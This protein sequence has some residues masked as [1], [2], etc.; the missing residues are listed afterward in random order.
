MKC[1]E[2]GNKLTRTTGNHRYT[3]CGLKNIILKNIP[4]FIC[5]QCGEEE[6]IIQN[7]EG[8]HNLIATIVASQV[9][10]LLPEEIRLLRTHLGFSGVDFARA[11]DVTPESVSRWET[12]KEKMS[13]SLERFLRT[14]ILY[15]FGPF[16]NYEL[17]LTKYGN[18]SKIKPPKRIFIAKKNQ[19]KEAA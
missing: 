4:I 6:F 16:R 9:F 7:M 2:C 10:R 13:L 1:L 5:S 11:I 14:L 15:R 17:D 12:G 8:L 3:T 18:I 19:W